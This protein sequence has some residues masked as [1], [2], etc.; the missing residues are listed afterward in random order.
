MST[1]ARVL[2]AAMAAIAQRGVGGTSL[3][4]VAEDVG[5]TKAAVLY[6]FDSKTDLVRGVVDA[7]IDELEVELRGAI[8]QGER[9][10]P[11]VERLVRAAFSIAA[12]RPEVLGL[13]REVARQGP[14]VATH[15]ALRLRPMLD[16]AERRLRE[17]MD[18]GLLR[19]R[20][21]RVLLLTFHA[22][23]VGVSTETEV[24]RAVGVAP[25]VRS[26]VRARNELLAMLEDALVSRL[27]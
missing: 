2:D 23:V 7:A 8:T 9:G 12:R 14:P 26:L 5:V 10:W 27:P 24:M 1:R 18:D 6:H 19:R 17:D 21:P 11:A 22:M 20:D 16:D 4:A 25:T 13:L 15:L 3:A